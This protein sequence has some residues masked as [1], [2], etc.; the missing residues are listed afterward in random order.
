MDATQTGTVSTD[1]A[2]SKACLYSTNYPD[3]SGGM[4]SIGDFTGDGI[5]DFIT[6]DNAI[7]YNGSD[8]GT[9]Y[10]LTG[11]IPTG[12][13]YLPNDPNTVVLY[14]GSSDRAGHSCTPGDLDGDGQDEVV[15]DAWGYGNWPGGGAYVYFGGGSF[16]SGSLYSSADQ[17][18]YSNNY[19]DYLGCTQRKGGDLNG[20]GYN[21]LILGAP[22]DDSNGNSAGMVYVITGY[23][24]MNAGYQQINE[25]RWSAYTILYG[26]SDS[27][28]GYG[29]VEIIGDLNQNGTDDLGIYAPN[30]SQ[31]G[32][33]AGALWVVTEFSSSYSAVISSVATTLVL[34]STGD[35]LGRTSPVGDGDGDGLPDLL[36]GSRLAGVNNEGAVFILP[37]AGF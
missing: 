27:Q 14:G 25:A 12:S 9:A 31:G 4:A 10:L 1:C 20:D 17:I 18:Y 11:P 13:T 2:S 3:G 24:T 23:S 29:S 8:S 19:Y 28:L 7:D 22:G 33:V 16:S 26:L 32:W 37:G 36:I 30:D 21:E 5:A 35:E 34:G 6:G 15:V